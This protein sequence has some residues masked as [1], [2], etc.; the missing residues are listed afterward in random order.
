MDNPVRV[1]HTI[2]ELRLYT[3]KAFGG[4]GL[5]F[6]DPETARTLQIC[7]YAPGLSNRPLA[8]KSLIFSSLKASST[9]NKIQVETLAIICLFYAYEKKNKLNIQTIKRIQISVYSAAGLGIIYFGARKIAMRPNWS[10]SQ[11]ATFLVK[12]MQ[13]IIFLIINDN[14]QFT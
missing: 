9:P 6:P 12:L 13:K 8:A 14:L 5:R 10:L 1:K 2:K 4:W 11:A 7:D 3:L